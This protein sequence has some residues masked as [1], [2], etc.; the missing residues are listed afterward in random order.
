MIAGLVLMP[1]V[2]ISPLASDSQLLAQG[3]GGQ[4]ASEQQYDIIVPPELI[5]S[6]CPHNA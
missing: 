1:D 2:L 5:S 3:S 6:E 4:T